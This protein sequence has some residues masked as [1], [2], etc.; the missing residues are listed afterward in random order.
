MK[1]RNF[2]KISGLSAG[3]VLTG[4]AVAGFLASCSGCKKDYRMGLMTEPVPV[5]EGDF[6]RLLSYPAQASANHTLTAQA[7]VANI[8][9]TNIPVLGYQPN[10]LLGPSFRINRG[11]AMNVLLQNNLSEHTNIH[12]HGLKIPALMD[13]H[14]DQLA[15][16]GGTFRYQFTVN[17]RAGLSW[18]HPH[19]HEMTGK[20]VFQGLAGMFIINDTEEAALSLPSGQYELPLVIQDKRISSNGITYNPS[21]EE[22]M[23]GYMGESIIVNGIYSS[24][25]EVATRY[26]RLRILNGSNARVYNLALSNNAD[27]IIIG[28]DGGLLKNPV[29]VKEILV[30]PGERLD[31]LVNFSS[32]TIGTEIY[33]LSKEFGNGGN[34]QGKQGFKIMKFKVTVSSAITFTVPTNLSAITAIV[35]S[36]AVRTRVFEISNAMEHHGVPMNNG[37]Q[38]RHRINGKLFDSSRIDETVAANTNEIWV[39]DNSMGDEPHPMHLHGVFFQVLQRSGGRGNLIASENGWK[40]TVLVMPGETVKVL[41]PFENNTGKFVFHCHNLEHEDDGMMLQYQL[42]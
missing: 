21:M 37:M 34:A 1:R 26:Y 30:A 14:P 2:I 20:Q 27:M 35:A 8:K 38:M 13:G 3:T 12:W 23:A 6:S 42:S 29:A 36:S 7:T 19:P 10:S 31:V 11:N 28:N 33:L 4:G 39:F 18:Y 16:A 22:V 32:S 17:Q 9:G 15:G 41:V 5:T 40:D 25:T 24:Y